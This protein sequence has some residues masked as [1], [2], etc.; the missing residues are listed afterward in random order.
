MLGKDNHG[1]VE[2]HDAEVD[3]LCYKEIFKRSWTYLIAGYVNYATTLMIF[4]ALTSTGK[5]PMSMTRPF[6][7]DY[8][9]KQVYSGCH[10][11]INEC[12]FMKQKYNFQRGVLQYEY[13]TM[14]LS[15]SGI[16]TTH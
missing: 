8:V 2:D 16:H 15:S 4:P 13:A 3:T 7:L 14:P 10:W 1:V 12:S 6:T 9:D 5:L 11:K